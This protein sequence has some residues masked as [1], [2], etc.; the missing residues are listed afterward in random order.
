[1]KKKSPPRGAS[2]EKSISLV[3]SCRRVEKKGAVGQG[4]AGLLEK[5]LLAVVATVLRATM[6]L[7]SL[8][9][10]L[11]RKHSSRV[12]KQTDKTRGGRGGGACV[13]GAEI[14]AGPLQYGSA[15]I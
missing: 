3:C 9:L 7:L 5:I 6:I 2:P 4:L 14:A 1:M 8:L 13:R 11:L 10:L 12:H 15:N